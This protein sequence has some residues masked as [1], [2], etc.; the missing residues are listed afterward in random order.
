MYYQDADFDVVERVVE[1]AGQHN[2][3]PAQIALAWVLHRPGVVAPII[4][5]T[6]MRHLEEAVAA[7]DVSL[8]AE[9]MAYLEAPYV[10]HQILGHS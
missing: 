7:L 2:V 9:E 4:G 10:A 5:A 1:T 6:K 3:S 8:S